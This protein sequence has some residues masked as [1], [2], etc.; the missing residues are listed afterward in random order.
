MNSNSPFSI[1]LIRKNILSF[2]VN[3]RCMSCH[4]CLKH[5]VSSYPMNY[6]SHTWRNSQCLLHKENIVCN[7]CYFYVWEYR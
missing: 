5:S 4:K 7:W 6:N 2:I 3:K 1:E